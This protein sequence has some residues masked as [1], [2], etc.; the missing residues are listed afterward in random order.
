MHAPPASSPTPSRSLPGARETTVMMAML[1][2]LN[3]MA[4]DT[5]LPALPAM[6]ADLNIAVSNHRQYVIALYLLGAAIGSL[7]YGPLA[8]R[9]G[10]KPVLRSALLAY[11]VFALAGALAQDFEVLLL[12]R[13][14]HGLVGA[15][16]GVVVTAIIRD[17]FSGDAMARRMSN[18]MLVFMVVPIIAPTIGAGINALAGWRAIFVVMAVLGL[19]MLLWIRRLP[20]TLDPANVRRLDVGTMASGWLAVT[21]HRRAAG[22]MVAAG[23]LQ[24]ALYGYLNSSE[25]IIGE[26]FAAR[27]AFPLVF[28]AIAAGIAAA[29]FSNARIVERFGARRVSQAALFAFLTFALLQLAAATSGRETLALFTLLLAFNVGLIGFTGSN[30]GAIA[31]EDFGKMAGIASS[32][33]SFARGLIAALVGAWIGQQFDGT[34]LP[35]ALSFTGAAVLAILLVLWA[36]RGRLF[37][38]P[39]TAPKGHF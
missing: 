4:I 5:M 17:L 10:R 38:R 19:A 34:T 11:A 27:E 30:F 35:L 18:I 3:A 28:A 31:M 25:Q 7:F 21:L 26:T 24:G 16:L 15:G 23:I 29:N 1:M 37:T 32:Y 14:G 36:E 9:F 33:Q 20:E 12:L 39:G 2:A 6:A 8:D 13:L 22:Y